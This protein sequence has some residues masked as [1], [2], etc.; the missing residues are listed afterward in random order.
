M[1]D[2]VMSSKIIFLIWMVVF[3][4]L[5]GDSF[6]N[7]T[8]NSLKRQDKVKRLSAC[9]KLSKKRQSVDSEFYRDLLMLV[10]MYA[11]GENKE[12]DFIAMTIITCYKDISDYEAKLILEEQYLDPMTD[13]NKKIL[14]LEKYYEL[15]KDVK[16][17]DIETII[18]KMQEKVLEVIDLS[19]EAE[20]MENNYYKINDSDE[21]L[22]RREAKEKEE[23]DNVM[24]YY[25]VSSILDFFGLKSF[26]VTMLV[27]FGCLALVLYLVISS[28]KRKKRKE[29]DQNT[30]GNSSKKK[31]IKSIHKNN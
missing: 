1:Q 29:V 18:L 12:G 22:K 8:T 25:K 11:E 14:H 26:S 28:L 19:K 21:E 13:Q 17:D 20:I 5:I 6:T 4:S 23:Y 3:V 2:W 31:Q 30:L 24:F 16:L 10:N 7:N 9:M 15:Y 27:I